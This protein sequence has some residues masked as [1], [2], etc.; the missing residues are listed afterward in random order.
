LFKNI[1]TKS[2]FSSIFNSFSIKR[3]PIYGIYLKKTYGK[4]FI[5]MPNNMARFLFLCPITDYQ[6]LID[7]I[8]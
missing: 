8:Y 5:F 2:D 6:I 4:I 1:L 3:K 7:I